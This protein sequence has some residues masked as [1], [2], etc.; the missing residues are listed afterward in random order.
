[1]K[2][3]C[4]CTLPVAQQHGCG[5]QMEEHGLLHCRAPIG[6]PGDSSFTGTLAAG[7]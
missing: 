1:M 7:W 3:H 4:I 6:W 2:A 5:A